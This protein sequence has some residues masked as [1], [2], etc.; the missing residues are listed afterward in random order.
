MRSSNKDISRSLVQVW[1]LRKEIQMSW[2]LGSKSARENGGYE[3]NM[4]ISHNTWHFRLLPLRMR[5]FTLLV[6][7]KSMSVQFYTA[8][9]RG[10]KI[11]LRLQSSEKL[12]QNTQKGMNPTQEITLIFYFNQ[13]RILVTYQKKAPKMYF[14]SFKKG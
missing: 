12:H 10:V 1:K 14:C 11:S 9:R 13:S 3:R 5:N 2:G 6:K 7:K 8:T 4:G